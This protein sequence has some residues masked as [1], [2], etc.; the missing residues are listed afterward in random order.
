M[1]IE[2]LK[3]DIKDK[4]LIFNTYFLSKLAPNE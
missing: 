4:V 3:S 2:M 1:E